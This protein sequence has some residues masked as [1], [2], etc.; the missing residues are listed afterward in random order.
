[1]PH[2]TP[3]HCRSSGVAC[4]G[5]K[6]DSVNKGARSLPVL[7]CPSSTWRVSDDTQRREA[8][9]AEVQDAK[10]VHA[11]RNAVGM[12]VSPTATGLVVGVLER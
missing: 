1:M 7:A 6:P 9:W 11:R 12:G 8:S 10:Y 3:H 5:L 4:G 2:H